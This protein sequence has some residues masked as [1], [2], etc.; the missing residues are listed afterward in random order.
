MGGTE[1]SQLC[2]HLTRSVYSWRPT[3]EQRDDCKH[4]L[5]AP[6]LDGTE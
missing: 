6:E 1:Y 3:R 5:E 2:T 4:W